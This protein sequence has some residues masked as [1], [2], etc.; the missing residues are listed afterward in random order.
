MDTKHRKSII[1]LTLIIVWAV[2]LVA[3]FVLNRGHTLLVDNRNVEALGLQA[4]DMILV[5]V[6]RGRPL[7]FLRGDR[8]LFQIGGGRR[9]IYIEFNDGRPPFEAY[10]KL[11]LGPDLFLLSIPK[12]I[13]GIEPYIEVFKTQ[14]QSRNDEEEPEM[15]DY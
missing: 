11:P 5:T 9:R 12:M 13:S 8:E 3:L 4:Q 15:N 1:R 7:E 6:D 10:F 14:P 2:L